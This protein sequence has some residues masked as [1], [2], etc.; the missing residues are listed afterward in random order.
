[1]TDMAAMLYVGDYFT[2]TIE[3]CAEEHAVLQRLLLAAW[4]RG[5][6]VFDLDFVP[7]GL[8]LDEWSR[9]KDAVLPFA[10]NARSRIAESLARLRIVCGERLPSEDWNVL[11][12]IVFERDGYKCVYCGAGAQLQ[13]DHVVPLIRGGSNA[14]DNVATACAPC[15]RSKG[16]R[17]LAEWCAATRTAARMTP[18]VSGSP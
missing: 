18:T 8:G 13:G 15:N 7:D 2:D 16:S 5:P 3:L 4:V 1:M 12:S 11:R 6:A 14:I 17:S 10:L 9:V